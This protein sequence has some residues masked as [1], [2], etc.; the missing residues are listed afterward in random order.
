MSVTDDAAWLNTYA[1]AMF[2]PPPALR[3]DTPGR[4]AEYIVPGTVQT[5]ALDLIDQALMWAYQT[6]DSR[7][8]ITM[9]PQEGKS[10]RV[11]RDFVL[12]ALVQNPDTRCVAASYGQDLA[13]RNGR[14][15]R[16]AI[17]QHPSLGLHIASDNGAVNDWTLDGRDGGVLSR[18]IGSGLTGR[19]ADLMV[20]DDPIKDPAEANSEVF[21]QSRWD[22]WQ[23]VA[24]TR[25]APGAPC[26]VILTRWHEDDLAGRLKAAPDGRRWRVLNIPAEAD[27]NPGKGE[28][29]VLGRQPGEFMR[30]ARKRT[31]EQWLDIKAS[32]S[33]RSWGS[34]YQGRPS[35]VAGNLFL[36]DGWGRYST[37]LWI[38][39]PNG[40]KWYPGQLGADAG[41]ELIQ[42]W[43]MTFKDKPES[44]YV[45]GQV[46]LR[47]GVNAYLLDEV[48]GRWS[49]TDTCQALRSVTSVWPQATRKLI[50]DT[51]N[52]PAIMNALRK[53]IGGMVPVTPEGSKYA[54]AEAVS[55][56]VQARNVW[57]PT[58]ELCPWVG[59]FIEECAGFPYARHDDQVDAFTQAAHRLLLVPILDPETKDAEDL[60]AEDEL[61]LPWAVTTY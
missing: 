57:L 49:F 2:E 8:I 47:D 40:Q 56:L 9:P 24:Q 28:T 5:P 41:R 55:P 30:S 10:T 38:G 42:S 27:H 46:W 15:V 54:R 3:W 33:A 36:R 51:A 21:R 22:W 6:P 17:E 1:A 31:R 14:A 35:P 60:L 34:L 25:L 53:Q 18:G 11:A 45:V 58:D 26:V 23:D 37:P 19:P 4:L 52:G 20:I 7:L 29:D 39:R 61:E 48:R 16:R 59:E 32:H 44:D 13:N 43:D 50:E 12:W